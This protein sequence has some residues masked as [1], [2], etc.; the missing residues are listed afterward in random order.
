RVVALL[1]ATLRP[2]AILTQDAFENA[3]RVALAVS[4]STNL[5][6]H[7]IAMAKEAGARIDFD[8][9]DRLGRETPTLAKL[10]PSGPWGV[11]ELGDAGG[12]PA[13]LR[14]LGDLI[15][16]EAL[17]VSGQT[18]GQLADAAPAGSREGIAR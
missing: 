12:V 9:I 5:V 1:R 16:R 10:A 3:L 8:T 7:L 4:G 2:S 18:A 17:T 11:T 13:V 14:E 6:L 15:H